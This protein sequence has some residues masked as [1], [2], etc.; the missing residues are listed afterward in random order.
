MIPLKEYI[1]ERMFEYILDFI[2][3]IC[4]T[5]LILYVCKA[6]EF[7]YGILLSIAYSLGKLIYRLFHYNKEYNKRKC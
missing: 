2:G 7:I 6:E 3:P 1:R 5:V 4:L